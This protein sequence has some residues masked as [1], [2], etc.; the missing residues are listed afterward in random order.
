[1][2]GTSNAT[3]KLSPLILLIGLSLAI[4]SASGCSR[5]SQRAT[6]ATDHQLEL[7]IRPDPPSTGEAQL[8]IELR[9]PMDEPVA[10]AQVT[11]RGD[12]NHAGMTPVFGR[13]EETEPGRYRVP[14]EWTMAGDWSVTVE[15]ELPDGSHVERQFEVRVNSQ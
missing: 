3:A 11:A 14:F 12:M 7:T 2:P 15:A 13:A 1:M 10:G 5:Q 6:A 4:S 8:V 9:D